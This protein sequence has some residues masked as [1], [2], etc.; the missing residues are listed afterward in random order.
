MS[1]V[2]TGQGGMGQSGRVRVAPAG[3]PEEVVESVIHMAC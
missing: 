2:F 1:N 3:L